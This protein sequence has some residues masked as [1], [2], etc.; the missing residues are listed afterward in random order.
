M[1]ARLGQVIPD[2]GRDRAGDATY[3][4]ARRK[5]DRTAVERVTAR[6]KVFWG[7]DDGNITG[8]RRFHAFPGTVM[9]VHLGTAALLAATPRRDGTMR[10]GKIQEALR[11]QI[12]A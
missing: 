5:K 4:N 12:S 7:A 11:E 3:L 1:V 10:L 2:L 8:A 9:V 6:L